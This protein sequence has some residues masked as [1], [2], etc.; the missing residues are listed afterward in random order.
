MKNRPNYFFRLVALLAPNYAMSIMRAR[1]MER[2]Y[3]G[4]QTYPSSDWELGDANTSA[5]AEIEKAQRTLIA[6]SRDLSRNSPYAK[7]AAD[8]VVSNT[9]GH[10][11]IPRLKGRNKTQTKAINAAW[12]RVAETPLCDSE[13][14]NNFYSLQELAMRTIVESGEVLAIKMIEQESPKLQLL[15]PDFIDDRTTKIRETDGY[16]SGIR[17]DKRNRRIAYRLYDTHPGNVIFNEVTSSDV[18]AKKII[19]TYKQTRPGQLRGVPWCHA[20]IQT[21]KDFDDFQHATIV[22]QKISACLVGV[23]TRL[24]GDSLLSATNRKNKRKKETRMTPGT[25]KYAEPGED[26]TFSSPPKTEGYSDFIAETIRAVASGYGI[27]YESLSN[28]YSKVNFSSGRMGNIE[29]RK[30]VDTW[31]WNMF[32]PIFCDGYMEMFKEWCKLT[33]IVKD[34]NDIQHQWV[35]PAHTMLDPTKEVAA[36]KEQVKAGFKSKSSVIR[37]NGEDPDIVRE[38]IKEERE[39]DAELGLTFDVYETGNNEESEV[40]EEETPENTEE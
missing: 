22:R 15:E 10:G 2:V 12:K 34:V 35:A 24:G 26:V 11:I 13:L 25:W 21:L 19:H 40:D 1:Y 38:E 14:R 29:M 23:I 27:T 18:S 39:K 9:V 17:V 5:N 6:R 16:V 33:G 31:R 36:E 20:I 28:D 7:K 30:N 8:V 37:S 3:T 4:A 32:I